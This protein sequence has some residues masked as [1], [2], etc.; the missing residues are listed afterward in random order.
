MKN[1]LALIGISGLLFFSCKTIT[2]FDESIPEE[3]TARI[4]FVNVG[5]I[6]SYNDIPVDWKRTIGFHFYQIPAGDTKLEFDI[7]NGN[8]SGKN[9]IIKYDFQPQKEYYFEIGKK[10][11]NYG[12]TVYAWDYGDKSSVS[13]TPKQMQAH[14]V[15][16][17]PFLNVRQGNQKLVLE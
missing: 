11:N 5:S 12:L 14:I 3:K 15:G 6:T 8:Y 9:I 4:I 13:G 10:D 1:L 7:E 17:A 2:A 16:F